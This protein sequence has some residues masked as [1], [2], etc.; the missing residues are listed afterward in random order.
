MCVF[1]FSFQGLVPIPRDEAG[2]S[3][4]LFRGL[5]VQHLLG[6]R[7]LQPPLHGRDLRTGQHTRRPFPDRHGLLLRIV[8]ALVVIYL[9]LQCPRGALHKGTAYSRCKLLFI[10]LFT[11]VIFFLDW[12]LIGPSQR[13]YTP[14]RMKFDR[15]QERI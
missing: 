9:F 2:A 15:S 5:F 3:S 14:F 6:L 8:S 1:F 10:Y 12:V 4:V 11:Q 7:R 13:H